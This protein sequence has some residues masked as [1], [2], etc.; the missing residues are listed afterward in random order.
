MVLVLPDITAGSWTGSLLCFL[1]L[2][3]IFLDIVNPKVVKVFCSKAEETSVPEFGTLELARI[4]NLQNNLSNAMVT[5]YSH[6][7]HVGVS[8]IIAAD[9]IHTGYSYDG[10]LRLKTVK[11]NAGLITDVYRY[12]YATVNP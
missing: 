1:L 2:P 11:D 4:R 8:G 9:G 3:F 12:N 7:P 6:R 10:L 5:W